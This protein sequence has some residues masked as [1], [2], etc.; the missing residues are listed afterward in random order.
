M[1]I[2]RK[3]KTDGNLQ[4][5]LI[6]HLSVMMV[7]SAGIGFTMS[8]TPI[9]SAPIT[10]DL[11][12]VQIAPKTNLPPSAEKN[13]VAEKRTPTYAPPPPS[14]REKEIKTAPAVTVT[15]ARKPQKTLQKT[16]QPP[17]KTAATAR[18]SG[19]DLGSLLASVEK[20]KPDAAKAP[21]PS[22]IDRL[23][24]DTAAAGIKGGTIGNPG[25]ALTVSEQD[26]IGSRLR[27]CWNIDA[28]AKGVLDMRVG[29]RTYLNSDGTVLDVRIADTARYNS[30]KTFRAIAD[31]ARRAV[32]VCDRKGDDSP[33]KILPK[34]YP[35]RYDVWREL[36]LQFNPLD[37]G[38]F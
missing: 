1:P 33:F 31:S 7:F 18:K 29:I 35:N 14:E 20:M 2:F 25:L 22:A 6:L 27:S 5:S 4:A 19:S 34:N 30:D 37:G 36:Y 23:A 11:A 8:H 10:V 13:A 12:D 15:D 16:Q 21:Q 3:L 28:G 24:D 17:Q 9:T 38:I 26:A 32:Y